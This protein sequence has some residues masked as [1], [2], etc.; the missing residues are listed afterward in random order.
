MP[1]FSTGPGDVRPEGGGD[2]SSLSRWGCGARSCAA[3]AALM[4]PE[5][6][7]VLADSRINCG[8]CRASGWRL[9]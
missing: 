2:H 5:V 9:L 1:G 8:Y 6:R 3:L 4:Q 7:A